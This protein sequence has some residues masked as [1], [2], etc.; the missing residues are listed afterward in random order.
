[1]KER[2]ATYKEQYHHSKA[3]NTVYSVTCLCGTRYVS[4]SGRNLK[5]RIHEHKK[6]S[7]KSTISLHV[8]SFKGKPEEKDHEVEKESTMILAMER[9]ARKR[10][11]M[12]SACIRTKQR[13][14]CNTGTSVTVSD[15]WKTN[16]VHVAKELPSL[17]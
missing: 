14:L 6:N 11:F 1:M 9:N 4:E 5:V 13:R 3:Q 16:L 7:S 17:D 15:I 2:F 12:E 10:H 8:N